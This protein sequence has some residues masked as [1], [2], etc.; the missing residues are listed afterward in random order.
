MSIHKAQQHQRS[1]GDEPALAGRDD[2][3]RQFPSLISSIQGDPELM[4]RP[5]ALIPNRCI[6]QC[7]AQDADFQRFLIWR[8]S[9]K[10]P[11]RMPEVNSL[12]KASAAQANWHRATAEIPGPCRTTA[13]M[14]QKISIA[15]YHWGRYLEISYPPA[16]LTAERLVRGF[17]RTL[18]STGVNLGSFKNY[19]IVLALLLRDRG[20]YIAGFDSLRF[21]LLTPTC[22]VTAPTNHN[23]NPGLW[24]TKCSGGIKQSCSPCPSASSF[25]TTD[26]ALL[27]LHVLT[28]K[29]ISSL[30]TWCAWPC[31]PPWEFCLN[32]DRRICP[33]VITFCIG[34]RITCSREMWQTVRR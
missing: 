26:V 8:K 11:P 22:Q 30:K 20:E 25:C 32:K 5:L 31:M 23:H 13:A 27:A 29:S 1:T 14:P 3:I 10:I 9:L 19:D 4:T 17:V 34:S 28:I 33:V 24:G 7:L 18:F 12:F 21:Y 6:I 2:L 15:S 16:L